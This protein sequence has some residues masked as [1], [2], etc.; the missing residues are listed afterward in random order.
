MNLDFFFLQKLIVMVQ[1][2]MREDNIILW[3]FFNSKDNSKQLVF[4]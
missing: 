4:P 3:V 1:I 2:K